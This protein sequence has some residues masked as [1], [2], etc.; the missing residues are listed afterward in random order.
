M[1]TKTKNWINQKVKNTLDRIMLK[2]FPNLNT[3]KIADFYTNTLDWTLKT[4]SAITLI[5]TFAW[6]F[7]IYLNKGYN[8]SI[9]ILLCIIIIELKKE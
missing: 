4:I 7:P 9:I 2:E 1:K 8:L 3:Q 6:Y 5:T